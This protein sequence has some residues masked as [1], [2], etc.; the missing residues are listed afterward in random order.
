MSSLPAWA[1]WAIVAI[2]PFLGPVIAFLVVLAV[3]LLNRRITG[4]GAT[5]ALVPVRG[6]Q[7]RR[8]ISSPDGP[9]SGSE[10]V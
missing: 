6:R 8:L 3:T 4:I 10:G 5:P 1:G 7:G 9:K 2:C